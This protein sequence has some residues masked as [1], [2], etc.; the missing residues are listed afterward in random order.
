MIFSSHKID[1]S[2]NSNNS[3]NYNNSNDYNNINTSIVSLLG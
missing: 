2:A 3:N 1:I